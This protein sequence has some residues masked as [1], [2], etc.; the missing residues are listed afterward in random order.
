MR[1]P[2]RKLIEQLPIRRG[3]HPDRADGLCAM[4]MVAWL[5]GEAHSDGPG[6]GT[7]LRVTLP[8]RAIHDK[9]ER[10]KLQAA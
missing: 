1:T 8:V 2:P 7:T 3:S 5:A 10:K 4:E 6:E 9:E